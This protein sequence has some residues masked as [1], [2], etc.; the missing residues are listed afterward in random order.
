V[1]IFAGRKDGSARSDDEAGRLSLDVN[2]HSE[3]VRIDDCDL[4]GEGVA[5]GDAL[6]L[7]SAS[8]QLRSIM[9]LEPDESLLEKE[10]RWK[11]VS[12]LEDG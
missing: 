10:G 8:G 2:R 12:M 9:D 11:R 1:G 3:S 6:G 5:V 4:V 7:A